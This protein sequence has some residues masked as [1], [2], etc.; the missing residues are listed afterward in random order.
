MRLVFIHGWGFDASFWNPLA[1]LLPQFA[2][3]RIDLGFFNS[4]TPD[5]FGNA[6]ILIG[7][8][9]GFAKGL[10]AHN[11]WQ[12]FIAINS[13]PRFVMDDKGIGC[14]PAA[15]LSHMKK[16]L[17]RNPVATLSNF[18]NLIDAIPPDT[19]LKSELN[20]DALAEGLDELRDFA[21]GKNIPQTPNLVLAS[22]NDPLVPI[23]TSELLAKNLHAELALHK[24]GGHML[25]QTATIWCAQKI[26]GFL[27][28]DAG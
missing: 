3:H 16:N 27:E 22:Q 26:S 25:P 23:V 6:D 18:Y 24:T 2:Q 1:D 14:V 9:L 13:F 7:H 8:S 20:L 11:N 12:A 15:A 17:S 5:D 10:R 28:G 4:H 21:L 19:F